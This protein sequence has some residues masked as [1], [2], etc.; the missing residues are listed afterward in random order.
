M[1]T[2][3]AQA[4]FG[5]LGGPVGIDQPASSERPRALGRQPRELGLVADFEANFAEPT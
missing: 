1:S 3:Q 2:E 5:W 4:H